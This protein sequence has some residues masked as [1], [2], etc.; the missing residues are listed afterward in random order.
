MQAIA[1][2][3]ASLDFLD[4]WLLAAVLA[5]AD[6]FVLRGWLLAL[7]A[8][9][10]ITGFIMMLF[11]QLR[12]V[13]QYPLFGCGALVGLG[14][15][16]LKYSES[17]PRRATARQEEK[18]MH[19]FHDFEIKTIDG[20]AG[21]LGE[22]AGKAVLVVNVASEC[23]LT[24]QY[25]GLEK[26]QNEFQNRGF[27]VLGLPCNQFGAQEPG[28]EAEIKAFCSTNYRVTFPLTSKIEVN[29]EG[30]HPLYKWLKQATG[31]A[32]IQ[33]NFEKFLIGKDGR[34][35]NRYSPK[36]V[37]EDAALRADIEREIA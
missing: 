28:T 24:P 37:P 4:W 26:L 3:L 9:A 7:A 22:F 34:I 27:S 30:A 33:W 32:D 16:W 20:K 17:A 31:G 6:V 18:G 35:I 2:F 15:Q 8:A 14:W 29:G 25:T 36:T 5:L 13:W 21:S 1:Q 10:G 12:W 23:G 19:N 11:P